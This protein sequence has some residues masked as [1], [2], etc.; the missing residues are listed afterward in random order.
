MTG[1]IQHMTDMDLSGILAL[2]NAHQKET[3][4]LEM[5]DLN[6][7][8]TNAYYARGVAPANAFLIGFDQDGDYK[9]PNF[10][11]FRERYKRFAYIDRVITANEARG[12]GLARALYENLFTTAKADGYS[13]VGCEVNQDPPNPGSDAFHAKLGFE[14]VGTATLANGKTVRYLTKLL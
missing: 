2:N 6:W 14:H 5:A 3:S 10:L 4:F 1:H 13:I 7:L 12:Q 9:S 8:V 11:W